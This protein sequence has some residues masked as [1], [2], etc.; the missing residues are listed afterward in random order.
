MYAV[1]ESGGKQYRVELGTELEVDRLE[2]EAGQ[3]I[4]FDRVLLVADGED[5]A[6]GQ[7][8]VSGATVKADVVRRDR[9][10]KIVV[11]KYRPKAR[12]RVKHGHRQ[13]LTVLRIADIVHGGKSARK[14][15]DEA[16]SERERLQAAA[17]EEARRQAAA[18]RDLARKLA[19]EADA[20]PGSDDDDDK[21]IAKPR[22]AT[23]SKTAAEKPAPKPASVSAGEQPKGRTTHVVQRL[24][25]GRG[26]TAGP[27]GRT[28]APTPEPKRRATKP[29]PKK[30]E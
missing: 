18:D 27:A 20:E 8:V 26:G 3:T 9:G 10:D 7:P 28:Q 29:K 24:S 2:A 25:P 23:R 12:T 1:I 21:A 16:R 14:Q 17:D 22:R 15:A 11:F 5:S 19:R 6:I 30:D 4:E 13:E